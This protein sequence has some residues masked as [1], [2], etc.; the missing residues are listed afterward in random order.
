MHLWTLAAALANEPILDGPVEP[1]PTELMDRSDLT[2]RWARADIQGAKATRMGAYVVVGGA[3]VTMASLGLMAL[4][5]ELGPYVA[6]TG[7]WMFVGSMP[8]VVGGPPVLLGGALRSRRALKERGVRVSALP[9]AF[10]WTLY[11]LTPIL[12]NV[13]GDQSAVPILTYG[14]AVALGFLQSHRNAEARRAAGLTDPHVRT[15]AVAR[16]PRPQLGLRPQL[17]RGRRGVAVVGRF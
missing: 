15:S 8:A 1:Y 6:G 12:F 13:P 7:G 16:A 3:T 5:D 11:G 14:G 4:Q 17:Q 9:G 10:G 2:G